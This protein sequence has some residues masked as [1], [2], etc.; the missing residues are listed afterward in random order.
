MSFTPH[1]I[2]AGNRPAVHAQRRKLSRTMPINPES[3][4]PIVSPGP[5]PFTPSRLRIAFAASGTRISGHAKMT[6]GLRSPTVCGDKPLHTA[7]ETPSKAVSAV[8]AQPPKADTH[9]QS[10]VKDDARLSPDDGDAISNADLRAEMLRSPTPHSIDGIRKRRKHV[11]K[12]PVGD[13]AEWKKT[14]AALPS[15]SRP[16]TPSPQ[17]PSPLPM[18]PVE[19]ATPAK[20]DGNCPVQDTEPRGKRRVSP[21]QPPV[22]AEAKLVVA[23]GMP[24]SEDVPENME[25]AELEAQRD[26][27]A[28][29]HATLRDRWEA[30]RG[31]AIQLKL[32]TEYDLV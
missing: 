10:D 14:A 6:A 5:R 1:R 24:F 21:S 19:P 22:A 23:E 3:A 30:T 26:R 18:L 28:T 16:T 12:D 13:L 32:R 4:I 17:Q 27:L 11:G 15:R 2:N 31:A 9:R 25:G 8:T 7:G 29:R 20:R